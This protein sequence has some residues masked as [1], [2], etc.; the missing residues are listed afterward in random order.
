MIK[1]STLKNQK[2]LVRETTA[3]FSYIEKGAEKT[4]E[5][6]VRYYAL[7]ISESKA[8]VERINKLGKAALWT[9][10]LEPLIESLPDFVDATEKPV[11]V[12]KEFLS[13]F[14]TINLQAI[15]RAIEEDLNRPKSERPSRPSG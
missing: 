1:V 2:A 9:D 3:P 11:K 5:I 12:T 8:Y 6:R 14:N 15:H 7:A 4:E 10:L 13:N